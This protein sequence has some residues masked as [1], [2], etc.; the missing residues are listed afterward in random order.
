VAVF[1]S[2]FEL[3]EVDV[4]VASA[5]GSVAATFS[6]FKLAFE[7][8]AI[9]VGCLTRAGLTAARPATVITVP[10]NPLKPPLPTHSIIFPVPFIPTP[11]IID[12]KPITRLLPSLNVPKEHLLVLVH[13]E[14]TAIWLWV[15]FR[16]PF[17][18]VVGSLELLPRFSL[19]GRVVE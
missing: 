15:V 5:E 18:D 11:V 4:A 13:N 6:V 19:D 9:G 1:L 3:A 8:R 12:V 17:S 16:A 7:G 2:A 10:I 14:T